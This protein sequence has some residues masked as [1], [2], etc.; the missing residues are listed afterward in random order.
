MFDAIKQL[1]EKT[2]KQV[3]IILW[4][5]FILLMIL[6]LVGVEIAREPLPEMIIAPDADYFISQPSQIS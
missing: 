2:R 3:T 5:A 1:P 6:A 4:I